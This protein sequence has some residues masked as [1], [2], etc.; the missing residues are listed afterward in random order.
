MGRYGN[1]P[2]RRG[3]IIIGETKGAHVP[4]IIIRSGNGRCEPPI[5]NA[6]AIWVAFI[7]NA[8][9][10]L[11]SR[12]RRA[13]KGKSKHNTLCFSTFALTGRKLHGTLYPGCRFACP[14]LRRPLGFQ[15]AWDVRA[16][17]Y[18]CLFS[19]LSQFRY[20]SEPCGTEIFRP[21]ITDTMRG[22]FIKKHGYHRCA[23]MGLFTDHLLLLRCLLLGVDAPPAQRNATDFSHAERNMYRSMPHDGAC[24]I[25]GRSV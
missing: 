4:P 16:M 3:A 20:S 14:G 1:T 23:R 8:R 21:Q 25:R 15:P 24:L 13:R 2:A 9:H 18:H 17:R 6:M 12:N 7:K 10:G 5:K 19:P 22:A 11:A